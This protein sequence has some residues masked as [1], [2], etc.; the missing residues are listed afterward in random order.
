MTSAAVVVEPAVHVKLASYLGEAETLRPSCHMLLGASL[1]E[2]EV[3]EL[4]RLEIE[5]KCAAC[6]A[7]NN[8]CMRKMDYLHGH[9]HLD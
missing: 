6:L 8:A 5:R 7:V 4:I 9:I 3:C 1:S 2:L